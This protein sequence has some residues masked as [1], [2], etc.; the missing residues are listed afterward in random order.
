VETDAIV[1]GAGP[2]RIKRRRKMGMNRKLW[3]MPEKRLFSQAF[4]CDTE[5]A[6]INFLLSFSLREM[7][8]NCVIQ[9]NVSLRYGRIVPV[10][11]PLADIHASVISVYRT[12]WE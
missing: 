8:I 3:L 2:Y 4:H 1:G 11:K 10:D 7:A 6:E 12:N 5:S 9:A